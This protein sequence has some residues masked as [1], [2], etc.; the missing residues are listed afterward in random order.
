MDFAG[1]TNTSKTCTQLVADTVKFSG[2]SNFAVN[3][4]GTGTKPLGASAAVV[5]E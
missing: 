2:N 3:C 5:V 1:G 4:S